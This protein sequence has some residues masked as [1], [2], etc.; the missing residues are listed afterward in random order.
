MSLYAI[1]NNNLVVNVI[2]ADSQ[3]IAEEATNATCVEVPEGQ[4][5]G[6]GFSYVDG[7]F[8][9]PPVEEPTE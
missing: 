2:V 5:A 8:V 3:E 9:S 1:I 7:Q 4:S 6:I